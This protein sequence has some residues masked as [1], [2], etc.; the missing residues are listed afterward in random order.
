M[1]YRPEVKGHHLDSQ[2][3]IFWDESLKKYVAFVR[4]NLKDKEN[5]GRAIARAESDRLGDFPLTQDLPVVFLPDPPDPVHGGVSV[6]D[7]YNSAAL[8]YPWAD[9]AYYMF[10]QAYYHYTR[11]L[12]E[13]AQDAPTNA[14]PIDTQFAASRDGL[15]WERYD[16][17]PFVRVGMK[18]EFDC[19]SARLI[20]G[21]VPDRA[22]RELYLYYRGSDWLHGWDRDERNRKLLTGLGLGAAQDTTVLSRLVICRDGFVSVSAGQSVG[23]FITPTLKFAGRRLRVNV[24][25]SATGIARIALL[26]S[27]GRSI[28]GHGLE[29][30]DLI[31]TA[32]EINRTVTWRGAADLP[33]SAHGA[34]R[35]RFVL[36]NTELY[37]FQFSDE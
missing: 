33:A 16:R 31:H 9:R 26:D 14:G 12:R 19:H 20:H 22:G 7:Y 37:A 25:T 4:R 11:S 32:N 27:S 35:L 8:R 5:Q 24:D 18:G 23:E 21:L 10:P 13:F 30:C 17:R 1:T 6:V 15:R 2:N 3:V 28:P 34:V 36:R 29:D